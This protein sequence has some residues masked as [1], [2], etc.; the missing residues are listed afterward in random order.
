[1]I[2][3]SITDVKSFMSH[4]LSRDTFDLF[5]LMEASVRK[6]VTYHIDG[7]LNADFFDSDFTEHG[8][9]AYCLWREVRPYL[10]AVLKGKKL[11]LSCKIILALPPA[12]VAFLLKESNGPFRKE[13]IEGIYLNILYEPSGL[14]ITTGISYRTFSLDKSL[15]HNVDDHMKKFLRDRGIS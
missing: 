12:S 2:S 11:P 6:D 3:I 1:M 15:E 4:L 8:G 9:R 14:T 7:H 5:C 10:F 13:D